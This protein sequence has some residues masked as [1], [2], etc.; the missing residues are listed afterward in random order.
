MILAPVQDDP[1]HFI[2]ADAKE[3]ISMLSTFIDETY[4]IQE[5][6]IFSLIISFLIDPTKKEPTNSKKEDSFSHIRPATNPDTGEFDALYF[7]MM[8][9]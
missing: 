6:D 5:E 8:Y 9:P 2:E 7:E 1:D 4:W 3:L